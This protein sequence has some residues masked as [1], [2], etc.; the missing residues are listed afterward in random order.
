[1]N[2]RDDLIVLDDTLSMF[3]EAKGTSI[4]YIH[5]VIDELKQSKT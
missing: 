2:P 1:M 4:D 5:P 3:P